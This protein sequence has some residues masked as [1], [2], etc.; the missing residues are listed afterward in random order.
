MN[1]NKTPYLPDDLE[2][3]LRDYYASPELQPEF[4]SRLERGLHS[5]FNEQEKTKMFAKSSKLKW[6]LGF[7]IAAVLIGLLVTSPTVVTAMKRLLGY[8][9]GVGLVD[10]TSP[11]RVL[12]DPVS[13]T[14]D[15]VT[16]TV[17][18]A[19]L[20]SDKTTVVYTME[21]I[22]FEALSRQEN[23]PGCGGNAEVR[24]PDG[25]L[26][27]QM[28][29][30]GTGWGTGMEMRFSYTPIPADVNEATLFIPCIQN[31]LT[32]T[33]PENWELPLHF[34]PAPPEM[35]MM[36]VIEVTPSQNADTVSENPMVLEKVIETDTG[37]IL[38]GKF[39]SAVLN[40]EASVVGISEGTKIADANGQ[41]VQF[42]TPEDLDTPTTEMGVFPWAYQL[43]EKQFAWPLTI[44]QESVDSEALSAETSFDFDTGLNP[45][46]GQEWI[47]DKQ[48]QLGEYLVTLTSIIFNG[49]GYTF[50]F[51][52]SD[53]VNINMSV[54]I[55]GSFATGG[56]GGGDG[57]GNFESS[58]VYDGAPP[59]GNLSLVF[60]STPIIQ[61]HGPWQ[62]EW[63]PED[64]SSMTLPVPT[65]APQ[66]CL[67]TDS[68]QAALSN[69]EPIPASLTGKVGVYGRIV[70]DGQKPSPD[71][72]G[73]YVVNLDGSKKQVI[74]EGVWSSLSPDGTQIA[75]AV[76]GDGLHIVDLASGENNRIPNTQNDDNV[77]RWS[78]DGKQ[79][80]FMRTEDFN[81]YV[82]N[83]D[84]TDVKQVN[85]GIDYEELIGWSADGASL[86]YG[87]N[88]QDGVLLNQLDIAS[89]AV[90]ELF[91]IKSSGLEVTLSPDG[92]RFAFMDQSGNESSYGVYTAALDGSDRRL[93]AQMGHWLVMRPVWSPDGNWLLMGILNT[94]NS[95]SESVAVAVNLQTCQIV[96]L[97][98]T[99]DVSSW[100]P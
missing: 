15:G 35:T 56:G 8:I 2:K 22:P 89:G 39:D 26:L 67:T 12:A 60:H 65:E 73:T 97:P 4:V 51:H 38:I 76:S 61:I 6:A 57:D 27:Q 28:A 98:L 16:I 100:V 96:P 81:L 79:I 3:E 94:D 99:G 11:F 91:L 44:T 5:K 55:A 78:P 77:P 41:Q 63:Q 31:T 14:R 17:K 24:L 90:R 66:A 37:Y 20:S 69:P 86:F 82:T 74:G 47:L 62:L 21:N 52:S 45:K 53:E 43:E 18:E 13:Q 25:S 58:M 48:L 70:E 83:L 95:S 10:T 34:I 7:A 30:S 33:L 50:K 71:N 59:V 19:V 88:T 84:G 49:D 36:P 72:Y 93:V 23:V 46:A 9:P 75:Y 85:D 64:A 40:T 87:I 42:I 92:T 68:W 32:G 29:G 80:A 54:E 1:K